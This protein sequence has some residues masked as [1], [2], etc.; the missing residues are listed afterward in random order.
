[1]LKFYLCVIIRFSFVVMM[2]VFILQEYKTMPLSVAVLGLSICFHMWIKWVWSILEVFF[3]CFVN[4]NPTTIIFFK[5]LLGG[6]NHK[7]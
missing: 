4:V 6:G 1:M 7:L 5:G 3:F 2:V